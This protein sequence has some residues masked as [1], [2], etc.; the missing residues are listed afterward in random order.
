MGCKR[1]WLKQLNKLNFTYKFSLPY[2]AWTEV[3]QP[4]S[5]RG[6]GVDDAG[7]DVVLVAG[8]PITQ[9]IQRKKV[10]QL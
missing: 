7:V 3:V 10:H 2:Q 6:E 5:G 1:Y 4:C 8:E 9:R